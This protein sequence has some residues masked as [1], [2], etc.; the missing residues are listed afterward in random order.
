MIT[1]TT[2]RRSSPISTNSGFSL[3]RPRNFSKTSNA[4]SQTLNNRQAT[5]AC[6]IQPKFVLIFLPMVDTLYPFR[7]SARPRQSQ[8]LFHLL[9]LNRRLRFEEQEF[10]TSRLSTLSP[11]C[12]SDCTLAS[13]RKPAQCRAFKNLISFRARSSSSQ[14][15][16][17]RRPTSPLPT[18]CDNRR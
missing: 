9:R 7:K 6:Y 16:S 11:P 5:S 18:N 8:A 1:I 2:A 4:L 13:R 3:I 15:P 10:S 14:A 12:G 17:N